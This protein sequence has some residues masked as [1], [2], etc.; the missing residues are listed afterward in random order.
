M[1][2]GAEEIR[3]MNGSNPCFGRVEVKH[4][5]EWGTVC[6]D[7]WDMEDVKVVCNQLGCGFAISVLWGAH[8]GEGTGNIWLDSVTY[9]GNESALSECKHDGWGV[10]N[11]VHGEDAGVACSGKKSSNSLLRANSHGR[12]EADPHSGSIGLAPNTFYNLPLQEI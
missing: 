12:K 9:L 11:C 8:F 6:D 5:N 1:F 3:L 10:H 7:L 2:A 4:E